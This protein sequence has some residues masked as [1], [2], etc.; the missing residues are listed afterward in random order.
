MTGADPA[1][2]AELSAGTEVFDVRAGQIKAQWS[3]TY[4]NQGR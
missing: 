3:E 1:A 2:F 4:S